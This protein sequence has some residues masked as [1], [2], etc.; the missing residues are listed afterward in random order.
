MTLAV[1][2]L[3]KP[4][5]HGACVKRITHPPIIFRKPRFLGSTFLPAPE[6]VF[7]WKGQAYVSFR[8]GRHCRVGLGL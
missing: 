2:G 6:L 8:T 7:E 3:R 1:F 5:R 4:T